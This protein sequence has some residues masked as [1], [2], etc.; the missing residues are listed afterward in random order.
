MKQKT[1]KLGLATLLLFIILAI[2]MYTDYKDDQM[3]DCMIEYTDRFSYVQS[4][5][6][7]EEELD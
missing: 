4:K 6:F 3:Q 5:A 1:S 7:C 2:F